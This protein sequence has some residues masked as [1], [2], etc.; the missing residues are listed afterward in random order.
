MPYWKINDGRVYGSEEQA[1]VD[2][3]SAPE[4]EVRLLYVDTSDPDNLIVANAE[5]LRQTVLFYG[6][7]LGDELKTRQEKNQDIQAEDAPPA[8]GPA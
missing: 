5:F 1:F 2:E 7:P 4:G 6:L 8:H 3:S